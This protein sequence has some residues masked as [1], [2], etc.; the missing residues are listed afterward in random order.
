MRPTDQLIMHLS[1][2][3]HSGQQLGQ[4]LDRLQGHNKPSLRHLARRVRVRM[5]AGFGL[6]DGLYGALHHDDLL[7]LHGLERQGKITKA[8][9]LIGKSRQLH[10]AQQ[11][12]LMPLAAMPIIL[13]MGLVV[14]GLM[15]GGQVV[16]AVKSI[17]DIDEQQ[18]VMLMDISRALTLILPMFFLML[19][20]WFLLVHLVQPR[21]V[22]P[23][24]NLAERLPPFGLYRQWRGINLAR[25]LHQMTVAG[26]RIDD[27]VQ[28]L[29]L[30]GDPWLR[31]LLAPVQRRMMAGYDLGHAFA[32]L[33]TN[34]PGE[35]FRAWW[36]S[37]PADRQLDML[38]VLIRQEEMAFEQKLDGLAGLLR[39]L[40][41]LMAAAS[42]GMTAFVL[43]EV[44]TRF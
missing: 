23:I 33:E 36:E 41:M 11:K 10:Q 28:M 9:D 26:S 44:Q 22:G 7:L 5:M 20:G 34:F 19:V 30:H 40:L 37:G 16:P 3:L 31:Q 35:A 4:V 24:R 27:A 15:I 18:V 8:L 17:P 25:F 13:T 39:M 32:C 1:R 6:A 43:F 29:A 14:I 38:A 2:S 12:R 21:W 42:L